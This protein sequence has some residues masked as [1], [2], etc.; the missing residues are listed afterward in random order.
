M[1]AAAGPLLAVPAH[2]VWCEA[3]A[4][5]CARRARMALT[6]RPKA[7][8]ALEPHPRGATGRAIMRGISGMVPRSVLR[9]SRGIVCRLSREIVAFG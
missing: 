2:I 3:K 6:R 9:A 7:G 5:Y 1:L 8:E 4:S